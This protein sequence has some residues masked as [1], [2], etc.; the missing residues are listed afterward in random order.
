MLNFKNVFILLMIPHILCDFYFQMKNENKIIQYLISY[1]I[2]YLCFIKLMIKGLNSILLIFIAIVHVGIK[3]IFLKASKNTVSFSVEQLLH[4][5]I[6]FITSY[7]Y[8][9][10]QINISLND[11]T[12][13][14]MQITNISIIDLITISFKLM[15]IHKPVNAFISI[16]M[17]SYK[18]N[19]KKEKNDINAGR[20]IGTLERIIILLLVS[21]KQYSSIGLVLT[22]KSV[23]RYD[24]ISKDQYF[25]EYYLLGTLLSTICVL[26]I[27]FI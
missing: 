24:K 9:E 6:I 15:F 22:A 18:I 16:I 20:I 25:A 3:F 5:I 8:I 13:A 14:F 10:K 2:T 17:N 21:I 12:I 4:I 23:A 7:C 27:S 26:F 11:W 1:C 19:I